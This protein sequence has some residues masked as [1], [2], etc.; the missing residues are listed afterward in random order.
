MEQSPF[1]HIK[2][3]KMILHKLYHQSV[4]ENLM[5]ELFHAKNLLEHV[6]KLLLGQDAFAV[7]WLHTCWSFVFVVACEVVSLK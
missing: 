4:E 5:L 1:T 6:E 3:P 7:E 2:A